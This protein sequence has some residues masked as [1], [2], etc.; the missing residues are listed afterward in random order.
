MTHNDTLASALSKIMN[1]EKIGKRECTISP[2]TT[3]VKKVLDLL[4]AHRYIGSYQETEDTKGNY[5]T[6]NLLG[7]INKLGVIKPRLPI[8]L[9]NFRKFEKRFLIGKGFG[10]IIISTSKGLMTHEEAREKKI[11]GKLIAYCY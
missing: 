9:E 5:L 7:S 1:A 3:M 10:I 11:G 4:N 6:I 2:S 8:S